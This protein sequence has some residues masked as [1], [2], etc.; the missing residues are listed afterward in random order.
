MYMYTASLESLR[1]SLSHAM[2]MFHRLRFA[3]V[4]FFVY[5]LSTVAIMMR[6]ADLLESS[7]RPAVVEC[8]LRGSRSCRQAVERRN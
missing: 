1:L 5:A 2:R 8:C 3:E 4:T 7:K 6:T